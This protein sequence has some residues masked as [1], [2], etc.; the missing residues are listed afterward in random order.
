MDDLMDALEERSESVV[1]YFNQRTGA[2]EMWIDP[3]INE[4]P[5]LDPDDLDW[6]EIP[7]VEGRDAFRT[8]ERFVDGV[9]ELDVQRRLR[10]ALGGQGVFRRFRERL[11]EYPDL[12]ARWETCRREDLLQRSLTFLSGLGIEPIYR[13]RSRPEA[14]PVQP[15]AP[16]QRILLH[17]LLLLGAPDGKTE[18]LDGR[19]SRCIRVG[20]AARAAKLFEQLAREIMELQGLGWRRSAVEGL[21]AIEIGPFRLSREQDMVWLDTKVP[22]AIWDAFT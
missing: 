21:P 3:A 12:Q 16:K 5:Q 22:R 7:R 18:M 6:V 13:L 11:S 19:V 4:W 8:L 20:S 9:A 17:H 1:P 14:T 15:T 2:V 10:E